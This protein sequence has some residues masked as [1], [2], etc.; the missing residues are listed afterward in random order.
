MVI[1]PTIAALAVV[2]L[3]ACQELPR[4][5][6]TAEGTGQVIFE[7]GFNR[8]Q[9]G[10]N[11]LTTGDGVTI[12]NGAVTVVNA[13]NHPAWLKTPL[14]DDV[15]IEFDAWAE[16]EEGDIKVEVGGDGHSYATSDNYTASGYVLIFGGWNNSLNVIARM[17]EHGK[18][19]VTADE[20]K[21]EAGRRYHWTITRTGGELVWEIDGKEL[22]RMNDSDPLIG[23][24][25]RNFA[26]NG[27]E[28]ET[29]FDNLVIESLAPPQE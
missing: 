2:A 22:L 14:P 11:W 12:E 28:A 26:F 21:V 6:S 20:P 27:W 7:D 1:R 24:G 17:D 15:R 29:H 3:G 9:L 16:T 13:H 23:G 18:N 8:G 5:Y 19:R 25:H 4:T 10:P